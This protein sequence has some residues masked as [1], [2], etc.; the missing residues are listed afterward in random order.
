MSLFFISSEP[1]PAEEAA[2][3]HLRKKLRVVYILRAFVTALLF[4][5]SIAFAFWLTQ[6]YK[7][8]PD[9]VRLSE[10]V[11]ALLS[12]YWVD[13]A[14]RVYQS[15]YRSFYSQALSEQLG[16][17]KVTF[18]NKRI[19]KHLILHSHI[20]PVGS[21][22]SDFQLTFDHHGVRLT[23]SYTES[24]SDADK[25]THFSG[26]FALLEFPAPLFSGMT[27]VTEDRGWF[28]RRTKQKLTRLK[29]VDLVDPLFEKD[30]D[31]FSDDPVE[32]RM[33]FNPL[34]IEKFRALSEQHHPLSASFYDGHKIFLTIPGTRAFLSPSLWRQ[35]KNSS[36]L[37]A[38]YDE[39]THILKLI[40]VIISGDFNKRRRTP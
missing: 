27:I 18:Q 38:S 40:D 29:R 10:F 37:S 6:K 2:L 15:A 23:L 35:S 24:Y 4:A 36:E 33:I 20:V 13:N 1:A 39:I 7:L 11:V 9:L 22:S 5:G 30:F 8:D 12:A 28:G 3:E 16:V 21:Y 14:R 26:T 25:K 31:A 19:P 34:F 17:A 32:A